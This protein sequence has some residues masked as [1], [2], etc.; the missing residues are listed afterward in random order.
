MTATLT[1]VPEGERD[2][3]SLDAQ[4]AAARRG[5]SDTVDI[6]A[7]PWEP[8]TTQG[9]RPVVVSREVG[10]CAMQPLRS[11]VDA[12]RRDFEP[13][14]PAFAPMRVLEVELSRPLPTVEQTSPERDGCYTEAFIVVRLFTKPLGVVEVRLPDGGLPAD[15]LARQIWESFGATINER[16]RQEGLAPVRELRETGLPGGT[17]PASL[18]ARQRFLATAPF[19]SVVVSTRNRPTQLARCL[20]SLLA[21]EYPRFE[22]IVVDNGSTTNATARLVAEVFGQEQRVRYVRED[23]PGLSA[24]RTRGLLE[25]CGEIVAFVDDD[26]RVDRH[27]LAAL[28]QGFEAGP[29]VACVTG[30]VLPLELETP[31]QGWIKHFGNL[32][33]GFV[34]RTFDLAEHRVDE[35]LYPYISWKLGAGASMA[36]RAAPLRAIGGFD[37]IL[38]AGSP[39]LSGEEMSAYFQLLVAGHQVVFEPASIVYHLDYGTYAQLRRQTYGYGVG[40]PPYFLKC[41]RDNPRLFSDFIVRIPVGMWQSRKVIAEIPPELRKWE[42]YSRDL[43]LVRRKGM[44]YGP[45]AF[46]RSWLQ[47]RRLR[48]KFGQ[49]GLAHAARAAAG[50]TPTHQ[51][52]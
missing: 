18:R 37:P 2:T 38:G 16:L 52:P 33:K 6:P 43:M 5:S 9:Q 40:L 26:V 12:L 30:L 24:A 8:A 25:A 11:F 14:A 10:S 3:V 49:I 34:Q 13:P 46:C 31:A 32:N 7:T 28:A 15:D 21:L 44:L 41:L 42:G 36:F 39:A 47:L 19:A 51:S 17:T 45:V 23:F 20:H 50:S 1:R 22:I 35:P 4:A 27:W 29:A 48:K